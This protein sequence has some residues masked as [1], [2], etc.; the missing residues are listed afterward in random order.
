MKKLLF[1]FLITSSCAN[2]FSAEDTELEQRIVAVK[3]LVQLYKDKKDQ[4]LTKQTCANKSVKIAS[5]ITAVTLVPGILFSE[6]RYV[7]KGIS[8]LWLSAINKQIEAF[9]KSV[10]IPAATLDLREMNAKQLKS[11]AMLAFNK[12]K[13]EHNLSDNRYIEIYREMGFSE[14]LIKEAAQ[15]ENRSNVLALLNNQ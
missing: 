11:K 6:P 12:L 3:I 5:L 7:I 15:R 8:E 1:L 10:H 14:Q 9:D 2:I 4:E 13:T